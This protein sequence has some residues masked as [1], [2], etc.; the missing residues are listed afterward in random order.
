MSRYRFWKMGVFAI[1]IFS[2]FTL[3]VKAE[4]INLTD[5]VVKRQNM[6]IK[7]PPLS[8]IKGL[9]GYWKFDEGEGSITKGS[10]GNIAKIHGAAWQEGKFGKA[11][12]F[13]GEDNYVDYGEDVGL[14]ISGGLTIEFWMK[15]SPSAVDWQGLVSNTRE[16]SNTGCSIFL[17]SGGGNTHHLWC[18]Y[19][20]KATHFAC[21]IVDNTWLH[22]AMVVDREDETMSVYVDCKKDKISIL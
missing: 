5:W 22:I 18:S 15:K 12:F 7:T 17:T 2:S 19:G 16:P 4:E 8:G 13:D 3:C 21:K 1:V 11:L 6:E 14:D 20:N 9:I 10:F